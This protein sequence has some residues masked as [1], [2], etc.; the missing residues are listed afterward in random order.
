MAVDEA[1]SSCGGGGDDMMDGSPDTNAQ[2]S[3]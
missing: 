3:A 1:S 2:P